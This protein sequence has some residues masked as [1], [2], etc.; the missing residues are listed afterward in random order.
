MTIKDVLSWIKYLLFRNPFKSVPKDV[1]FSWCLLWTITVLILAGTVFKALPEI[2]KTSVQFTNNSLQA[3]L[4]TA[5]FGVTASLT[6]A[7]IGGYIIQKLVSHFE[8][9]IRYVRSHPP[10]VATRQAI[11]EDGVKLLGKILSL[12]KS[13]SEPKF[14]RVIVV[15][16]SLGTIVGY[17]ILTHAFARL[18]KNFTKAPAMEPEGGNL[19]ALIRNGNYT[20]KDY[21]TQQTKTFKELKDQGHIW[22]V[23]DFITLGSPLTHA[24]FLIEKI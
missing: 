23:T 8:D 19:E 2:H 3:G 9:V 20:P 5:I 7:A 16:H 12:K 18:N 14:N 4:G 17:D 6:A 13:N 24:E 10:N 21:Q 1:L 22:R 11:R 15:A